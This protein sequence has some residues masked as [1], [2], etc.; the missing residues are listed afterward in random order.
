MYMECGDKIL[1]NMQD[2][3]YTNKILQ[4]QSFIFSMMWSAVLEESIFPVD[5]AASLSQCSG[6]GFVCLFSVFG[7]RLVFWFRP[8]C[9]L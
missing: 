8:P 4:F 1:T 5:A 7:V 3:D 2:D 9:L 6:F